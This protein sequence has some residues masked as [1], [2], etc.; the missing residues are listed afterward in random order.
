MESKLPVRQAKEFTFIEQ[1]I[2]NTAYSLEEA[3]CPYCL[4]LMAPTAFVDIDLEGLDLVQVVFAPCCTQLES[5]VFCVYEDFLRAFIWS[6]FEQ[7]NK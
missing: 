1:Q 7:E 5:F 2:V 6:L 3:K 4:D